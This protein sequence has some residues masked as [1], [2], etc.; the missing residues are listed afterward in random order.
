MRSTAAPSR[1]R[2]SEQIAR[3]DL[4]YLGVPPDNPSDLSGELDGDHDGPRPTASYG[5]LGS[6]CNSRGVTAPHCLS[7]KSPAF[8]RFRGWFDRRSPGM[9]LLDSPAVDLERL[10]ATLAPSRGPGTRARPRSAI[11]PTTPVPS[12]RARSTSACRARRWTGTTSPPERSRRARLR[13]SSTGRSICRSAARRRRRAR[14]DGAG[15]RPSSSEHPSRELARRRGHGDERQDDDHLSPVRD[16]R[17]GRN[18][19]RAARH[20]R[21]AHRG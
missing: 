11:S 21:G 13:S 16:P 3:F 8:E 18:A 1:R 9:P 7:R 12:C 5:R 14:G 6:R 19:P 15:R 2:C 20:G 4:Q 17:G 10:I